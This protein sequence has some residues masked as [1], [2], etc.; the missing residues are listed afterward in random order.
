MN[1]IYGLT[2]EDVKNYIKKLNTKQLDIMYHFVDNILWDRMLTA[3]A[4]K[5]AAKKNQASS[6]NSTS[7][8]N[9]NNKKNTK[10]A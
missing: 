1:H 4:R 5:G 9:S 6:N 10:L 8:K 3:D 7:K 2:R